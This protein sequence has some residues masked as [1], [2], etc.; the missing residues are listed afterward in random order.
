MGICQIWYGTAW[1]QWYYQFCSNLSVIYTIVDARHKQK[2]F[3]V[4]HDC[5]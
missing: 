4:F 1:K 3:L 2:D 5:E